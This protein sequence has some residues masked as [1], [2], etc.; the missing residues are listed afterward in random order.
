MAVG[1]SAHL[2]LY[3]GEPWPSHRAAV[4]RVYDVDAANTQR[5]EKEKEENRHRRGN[6]EQTEL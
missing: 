1:G 3:Q 6:C 4:P 2:T 5:R